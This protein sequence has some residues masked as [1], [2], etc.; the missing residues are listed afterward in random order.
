[1]IAGSLRVPPDPN[2]AVGPSHVVELVNQSFQV[3][4]KTGTSLYGPADTNTIWTGFGG[5]C[6]TYNDGDGTV[7]YDRV[8]DRGA[9][10]C[11]SN[12]NCWI[13]RDRNRRKRHALDDGHVDGQVAQ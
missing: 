2:A 10:V 4:S 8:A 7:A 5:D 13:T 12:A 1:L 9:S 3:F 11:G 6:E